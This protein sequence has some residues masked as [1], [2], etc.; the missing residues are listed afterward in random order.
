MSLYFIQI[1]QLGGAPPMLLW[2]V[3]NIPF[4]FISLHNAQKYSIAFA[5][6]ES[7]TSSTKECAYWSIISKS[8]KEVNFLLN[9]LF[10]PMYKLTVACEISKSSATSTCVKPRSFIKIFTILDLK[11]GN[12]YLEEISQIGCILSNVNKH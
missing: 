1:L 3:H 10:C 12:R 8:N 6:D 11:T 7:V 5:E 4:R 2:I 9:P